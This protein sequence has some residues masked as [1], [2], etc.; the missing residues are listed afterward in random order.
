M[1]LCTYDNEERDRGVGADVKN[2][3]VRDREE[4]ER[5]VGAD[6]NATML[7]ET[8]QDVG[9]AEDVRTEIRL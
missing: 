3:S 1:N 9:L 2:L 4:C 5:G 6:V 7:F 8:L